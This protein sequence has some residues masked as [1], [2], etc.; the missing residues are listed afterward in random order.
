MSTIPYP[1]TPVM[2]AAGTAA[3]S[4]AGLCNEQGLLIGASRYQQA[5]FEPIIDLTGGL[6]LPNIDAPKIMRSVNELHASICHAVQTGETLGVHAAGSC[7][8]AK[9]YALT[10]FQEAAI[11]LAGKKKEGQKISR[12]QATLL[13]AQGT[14]ALESRS[15]KPEWVAAMY[16]VLSSLSDRA[17]MDYINV[18]T[19]QGWENVANGYYEPLLRPSDEVTRSI[20]EAASRGIFFAKNAGDEN[21]VALRARASLLYLLWK[22]P[23]LKTDSVESYGHIFSA[24]YFMLRTHELSPLPLRLTGCEVEIAKAALRTCRRLRRV[25]LRV[26][27]VERGIREF[28]KA[29][30]EKI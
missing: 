25:T 9:R 6:R 29:A 28:L 24:L 4:C 12:V 26:P 1:K 2:A 22:D 11:G 20:T 30:K 19:A 5:R 7:E 8:E 18:S 27:D 10:L 16:E 15:L 14:E 3:Q 21:A 17:S 13:I 23:N